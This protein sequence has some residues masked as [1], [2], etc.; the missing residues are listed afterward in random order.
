MKVKSTV[1]AISLLSIAFSRPMIQERL[2]NLKDVTLCAESFGN[3]ADPA[4]LLIMG[5]TASMSWWDQEFCERLAAE[6]YFVIRYDNRDVGRSSTY[7]PGTPPYGLEDM[8]DDAFGV[9]DAYDIEHAHIVGMSLGG[10][11]AQMAALGNPD[12]VRSLTLIGTGP[13]GPSDPTIPPMDERI[14]TFQSKAHEVDWSDEDAVISYLVEGAKLLSGPDRPY[15]SVRGEKLF[16][17]EFR[18]ANNYRSMY[19]HAGLQG[20]ETYYGRLNEIYQPVLLI[21]GTADRVWHY[22]HALFLSKELQHAHL[23]PLDGA[24]HELHQKD[25]GAM[26]KAISEHA[27]AAE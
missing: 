18:R 8:M 1:L 19:N 23:L 26:I 7:P 27:S 11:L 6:G 2:I 14:I 12:R 3:K 4:I 17:R 25:W 16:R 24:G 20:G 5:A 22:R 21:H 10:L 15:D 13:F 9:L